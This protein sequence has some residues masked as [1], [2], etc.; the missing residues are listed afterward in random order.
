MTVLLQD[1]DYAPVAAVTV[2]YGIGS[3][4]ESPGNYGMSHFCEHMMFKGFESYGSG[5]YW[6]MVQM[7][8]GIA[9]AYTSRET[10]VYY[11]AIPKSGLKD[12]LK[13]EADRMLNSNMTA[14]DVRTER[15]VVL[16]EELLTQR[17]NPGGAL[18]RLLYGTAFGGHPFGRPI[19]GTAEDIASFN[20]KKLMDFYEEYYI[21]ANAVLSVVGDIDTAEVLDYMEELFEDHTRHEP[22]RPR[23]AKLPEQAEQLRAKIQHSS[24]LPRISIGFRVPGANHPLSPALMLISIYLASGRSSRFEELL[25]RPSVALDVSASTNTGSRTG[26]YTIHLILSENGDA[27]EAEETVFSELERIADKGIEDEKLQKLKKRRIARGVI[28]DANPLSR[29]R[30]FA[31]G[32]TKFSDPFFYWKSIAA[33]SEVDVETIREAASTFL[34]RKRSTLAVLSPLE[35]SDVMVPPSNGGFR[36]GEPDLTPPAGQRP[37][38][39][40]VPDKLLKPSNTSVANGVREILMNNGIRLILKKDDSFPIV[41]FGFS[42]RMGSNYE[43]PNLTGLSEVTSEAMLYGTKELDSIR[44][45]ARLE[46]LGTGLNF[47]STNEYAGG[48]ITSLSADADTALSVISDL[49]RRPA[50]RSGDIEAVR[51]DAIS[52]LEEWLKS[53]VGAAVES[54]SRQSTEPEERSSV[55]TVE[56][57]SRISRGDVVDFHHRY[58]RPARTVLVVV[59]RF[60]ED[61]IKASVKKQFGDWKDP[62]LPAESAARVQNNGQSS[63]ERIPLSGREQ[64]AVLVGTPA[65][66]RLHSDSYAVSLLNSILGEGVGSR[67]GRNI[68]EPGLSYSANSIYIPLAERGRLVA[69]VLTSPVSYREALSRLRK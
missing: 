39:V 64:I 43:P 35:D 28:T 24:H 18:D 65:P 42:C 19:T 16:E 20:R 56:S 4:W 7:N 37:D 14:E 38:S 5:K 3:I 2:S 34:T 44:F 21:P 12:I 55:P 57:L 1:L 61:Q 23:L 62:A 69:L 66:P 29:S 6:Q 47:S 15:S 25:I 32:F 67:L 50:F 45:N 59:G 27:A 60:R 31:T 33:C 13:L 17:D 8:G 36:E 49:L 48:V 58:C 68:R 41:S 53:P 22:S 10:T 52:S 30:R 54:F 46:D 26:L 63:T 11:S 40:E 9:N 51:K